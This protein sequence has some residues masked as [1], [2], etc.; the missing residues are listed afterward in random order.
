MQ[1]K[2]ATS[3]DV[4][5]GYARAV[6]NILVVFDADPDAATAFV[7]AIQNDSSFGNWQESLVCAPNRSYAPL[8]NGQPSGVLTTAGVAQGDGTLYSTVANPQSVEEA[9]RQAVRAELFNR[10]IAHQLALAQSGDPSV[11]P[12]P[13]IV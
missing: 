2:I 5:N 13:D 8:A 11:I 12:T 9:T 7:A 1:T 6:G 4:A 10:V 3:T